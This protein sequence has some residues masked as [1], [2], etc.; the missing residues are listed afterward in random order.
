MSLTVGSGPAEDICEWFFVWEADF[1]EDY[2]A[3]A[4]EGYGVVLH[5]DGYM[6]IVEGCLGARWDVRC[7]MLSG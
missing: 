4:C 2:E 5:F 3:S 7:A 1:V 6:G